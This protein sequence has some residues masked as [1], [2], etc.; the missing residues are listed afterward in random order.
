MKQR[1]VFLISIA[2]ILVYLLAAFLYLYSVVKP[3]LHYFSQQP[4]FQTNK[5]FFISYLSTPGG[6]VQYFSLFIYQ[7]FFFNWL[8]SLIVSL[9]LLLFL[10]LGYHIF[11]NFLKPENLLFWIFIPV[12]LLFSLF[13][14][15][16]F[17]FFTVTNG[18][19]VYASIL[20]SIPFLKAKKPK[21]YLF[22]FLAP[23]IYYLTGGMS[24]LVFTASFLVIFL[25]FSGFKRNILPVVAILL[26]TILLPYIAFKYIF[27]ISLSR[28]FFEYYI[29]DNLFVEVYRKNIFY[30]CFYFSAPV[31]LLILSIAS[32]FKL[33]KKIAI[34]PV[35]DETIVIPLHSKFDWLKK[36]SLVG[37]IVLI[38][39]LSVILTYF[40]TSIHNRNI[41]KADYY[42]ANEKWEKVIETV[43]SDKEYDVLFNFY[44]NRAI[45]NLDQYVDKY[46][47]YPQ[48]IG[49]SS[50]FP[51]ELNSELLYTFYS[52]YYF[53]LGYISESQQWAYKTLSALPYSPRILK[54]FVI[55]YLIQ[56]EYKI[57]A[58]F[59]R[60][61]DDNILS[62]DF[63]KQYT[64]YIQDTSLVLKD[65]LIMTKRSFMPVSII[66]PKIIDERFKDLLDMNKLNKRAYEH[67]QMNS[68]L[69][70]QFGTFYK[71]LPMA[72]NYY[73][74]LPQI[75]EEALLIMSTKNP[76]EFYNLK[77][78]QKTLKL[79]KG[80]SEIY[81]KY[82]TDKELAKSKLGDYKNTLFY[83]ILFDS[84]KVTNRMPV[85]VSGNE[86]AH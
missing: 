18:I 39:G 26:L 81:A 13:N 72:S 36:Y 56:G 64:P 4:S 44:Y 62:K 73:T 42:C 80:F 6:L 33:K 74:T 66:T 70:H 7:L 3:E 53:D 37:V 58:K 86:Y 10:V 2:F 49:A 38:I 50:T 45:D 19:L 51:D 12:I 76:K 30:Y 47:D 60:I 27:N 43:S 21:W 14:N 55:T 78:N 11:R 57:A 54:R 20:F 22:F 32:R 1:S 29:V 5:Y 83:Y 63:V 15:Y 46:F 52:D 40:N 68:L 75:F 48:L 28:S 85:K 79:F 35:D 8:G 17:S 31:L 9:T 65:K 71:N 59:L 25:H 67:L 34:E 16:L 84:P 82:G 61:L 69:N 24:F 77:V 41:V 23:V